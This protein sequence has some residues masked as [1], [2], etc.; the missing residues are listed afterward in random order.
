MDGEP[1]AD[2]TDLV[3]VFYGGDIAHELDEIA[4]HLCLCH[5]A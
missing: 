3:G 1:E 5:N 2:I 4:V